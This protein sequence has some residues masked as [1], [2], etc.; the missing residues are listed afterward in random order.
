MTPVMKAG[1]MHSGL[2]AFV[3][4]VAAC[5]VL[6]AAAASGR[7][8]EAVFAAPPMAARPM[9]R[10]WWPG[11]MVDDRTI[12]SELKALAAAGYG[13]VEIQPFRAG[14]GQLS[15]EQAARV[16]DY[17]TPA[18]FSHVA[19]AARAA[20]A[21][22]MSVDLTLGSGWPSGGGTAIT[23]ELAQVELRSAQLVLHGPGAY[24]G[25]VPAVDPSQF[26][27]A[28]RSPP[29]PGQVVPDDWAPRFAARG[30]RIAL[31]AIR[32][33]P[34]KERQRERKPTEIFPVGVDTLESGTL[35]LATLVDLTDRVGPDGRLAWEVPEGEW[36]LLN[37]ERV[38]SR[39][40]V[41][42][43]VGT[44]PQMVL[45]HFNP[46][47]ARAHAER[48][49]GAG[50]T[51][52]QPFIGKGLR[53]VFVDSFELP[54]EQYWSDDFL[55]KFKARRG[56][57]LKPYL[58]LILR[59][60]WMYP[61]ARVAEQPQYSAAGLGPRIEADYQRTIGE[62][63][64][65]GF[66][67]PVKEWAHAQ[68]Y[69]LRLQAH[70]APTDMIAAYG[71]ADIPETEDLFLH[72]SPEFYAAAR[73]AADIYGKPVVASE[74]LIMPG[75]PTDAH[76]GM[77]KPRAD[78][79]LASG[80]NRM[81]MHG[82]AYPA[83]DGH[84]AGWLPFAALFGSNFNPRNPVFSGLR[85][86]TD[87]VARVQAV[88]QRT[89]TVA[90]VAIYR[91]SLVLQDAA[92]GPP[93]QLSSMGALDRAGYKADWLTADALLASR[94]EGQQLVMP[95][96]HRFRAIVLD[97]LTA[98]RPDTAERLAR[99]AADGVVVLASGALPTEA[100][101]LA[102]RDAGDARVARAATIL[103]RDGGPYPADR[104][105][106]EL[107]ARKV[108]PNLAFA[109]SFRPA[110]LE[111]TDG[112]RRVIF[113]SNPGSQRQTVAF[114]PQVAGAAQVWYPWTGARRALGREA[115]SSLSL[116]LNPHEAVFVVIDPSKAARPAR[117]A[118]AGA[119]PG[120]AEQ[121]AGPWRLR[122]QGYGTNS[123]PVAQAFQLPR[124]VDW[125]ELSALAHA[126]GQGHYEVA[127]VATAAQAAAQRAGGRML[128]DLGEVGDVA[129]V[130]LNGC[131]A[132]VILAPFVADI[133]AALRPGSN[134]LRID[135][136][137]SFHNAL[138]GTSTD[139]FTRYGATV[140]AGLVGPVRLLVGA[141]NDPGLTH[142][143][144]RPGP[145]R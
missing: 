98:M 141:H 138:S 73:S 132:H 60:Q 8:L 11:G 94:V 97:H 77:W 102:T 108:E 76:P 13:G 51:Q 89:T 44:G 120:I 61:Y 95:S 74:S 66:V 4:A 28:K 140:G 2:R 123:V 81:I 10:W 109:G 9:V 26:P 21:L 105:A 70:G 84:G 33:T 72:G 58:P 112:L 59:R 5:A 37:L 134:R 80:V 25:P 17:A 3:A 50:A 75:H 137:N 65:E 135:V 87:Y 15:A 69:T 130:T 83:K 63:F 110:Y 143:D 1:P 96:G 139:G 57:D 101:G 142:L 34:A 56:Y 91:D 133:T 40:R 99:I 79:L 125:R 145:G 36:V 107:S 93:G 127:L 68:G 119:E 128:L 54:V 92:H 126:S 27:I 100:S 82:A 88:M 18:F 35:D 114:R 24:A 136:A 71:L 121:V 62:L 131:A 116:T 64:Q 55:A 104:L 90:P 53:S 32:G 47:A 12:A 31:L 42:L 46:A 85:P 78:S 52:L 30:Q 38:A 67:V 115:D 117:P 6:P 39:A 16:N 7:P 124:L 144:C 103:G 129:R 122:F 111:K 118:A 41:A 19:A 113:L 86:F 14:L 45:D 43:S 48:V 106:A 29:L 23:P 49:L 20:D 22:G